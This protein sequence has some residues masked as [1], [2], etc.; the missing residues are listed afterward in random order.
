VGISPARGR[1]LLIS[2]CC[3]AFE[4]LR[5]V[6]QLRPPQRNSVLR[7]AASVAHV[8]ESSTAQVFLGCLSD[9]PAELYELQTSGQ[10][11]TL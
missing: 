1:Y 9:L 2:P 8:L 3:R 4:R 5:L 10:P 6:R 11:S 7:P